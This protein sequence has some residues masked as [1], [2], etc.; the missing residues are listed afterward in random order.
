MRASELPI[1][2]PRGH[3]LREFGQSDREIIENSSDGASVP[4]ALTLLNGPF[5]EALGDSD[6]HSILQTNLRNAET[7]REK[8]EI[9]CLSVLSRKPTPAETE[10]FQSEL[11]ANGGGALDSFLWVVLNSQQFRFIY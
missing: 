5:A 1:P 3:F 11:A 7:N 2:A 10:L 9:L 4:Q 6:S 8:F